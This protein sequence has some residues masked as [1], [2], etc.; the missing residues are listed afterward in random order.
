[1]RDWRA[2]FALF[3]STQQEQAEAL[4]LLQS[5]ISEKLSGARRAS[6]AEALAVLV[7]GLALSYLTD[8][9]KKQLRKTV[10]RELKR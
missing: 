5:R 3:G 4:G 10:I 6:Q 7:A 8:Q 2:I 9:E 1:M